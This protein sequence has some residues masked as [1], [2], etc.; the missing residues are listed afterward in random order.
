MENSLF[1]IESGVEGEIQS[2]WKGDCLSIVNM[3]VVAESCPDTGSWS[4][5]GQ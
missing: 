2:A 1:T 4:R 3:E 5:S